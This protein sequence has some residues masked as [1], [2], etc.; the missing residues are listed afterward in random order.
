MKILLNLFWITLTS[1]ILIGLFLTV[2][3]LWADPNVVGQGHFVSQQGDSLEFIKKQLLYTAFRDVISQELKTMKLDNKKF[4]K[5]YEQ[6]FSQHFHSI[7]N[8]LKKRFSDK[9]GSII[10]DK[11]QYKKELR[12]KKLTSKSRYGNLNKLIP[13][14][15]IKNT[16][17]SASSKTGRSHKIE[18]RATV[19]RRKLHHTYLSFTETKVKKTFEQ[20]FISP[21]FNISNI[22]WSEFGMRSQHNFTETVTDHWKNWFKTHMG[23]KFQTVTIAHENQR[24]SVTNY[25][26]SDSRSFWLTVSVSIEQV[27]KDTFFN[28]KSFLINTNYL[29]ID[30]KTKM[31]ILYGENKEKLKH[32][33]FQ[34]TEDLSSQLATLV[35]QEPVSLF[36]K[37]QSSIESLSI[38]RDRMEIVVKNAPTILDVLK[39]SDFISHEGIIHGVQAIVSYY[40]T[41]KSLITLSYTNNKE[42]IIKF[43]KGL[44]NRIFTKEKTLKVDKNMN[45]NI[46]IISK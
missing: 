4:W 3:T 44:N 34:N 36:D 33:E 14:Y 30:L 22:Q 37:I 28:I 7:S 24:E 40:D 5:N 12:K 39:L 35:Y 45:L 38:K 6:Q 46:L 31:P 42:D 25:L 18:I 43:V 32:I 11:K 41:S 10:A 23:N 21:R 20:L 26:S 8:S 27:H 16:T 1:K 19:N 15:S 9:K 2:G 29:F 17:S 13:S